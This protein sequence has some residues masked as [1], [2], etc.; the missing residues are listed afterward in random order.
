MASYLTPIQVSERTGITRTTLAKWR[1]DGNGPIFVKRRGRIEYPLKELQIWL[2]AWRREQAAKK[3][4]EP[5]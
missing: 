2:Q 5:G 3:V 4:W 1:K